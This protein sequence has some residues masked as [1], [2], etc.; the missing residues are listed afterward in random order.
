MSWTRAWHR[1]ASAT[2]LI[3]AGAHLALHWRAYVAP[4][5]DDAARA[6]VMQAMQSHLLYPPLG[7]TLWTALGFF[8]LSYAALLALFGTSQWIVA[9]ESAPRVLRRHS[10]RNALLCAMITLAI[11]LLHPMPQGLVV[12]GAATVL[13]ALAALPRP[14]DV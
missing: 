3:A 5:G 14:L 8:S 6:S 7:T 13:Y 2:L 10:L 4:P 1:A 11:W 12:F 9:R